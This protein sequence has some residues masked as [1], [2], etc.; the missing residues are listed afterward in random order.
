[1]KNDI[2][3]LEITDVTP[4]GYGIGRL[5]GKVYFVADTVTGDIC[6]CLVLKELK[7]HSFAKLIEIIKPSE[8][9]ITPNCT[10]CRQC[11][12]CAYRHISYEYELELKRNTVK[13]AFARIAKLD[14]A[15][16]P[17]VSDNP[18]HYRNKVQYPFAQNN[19]YAT[20]GY[21]AKRSHRIV[22]HKSCPLQDKIFSDI[23]AYTAE[24]ADRLSLP[25][26]D[27]ESGKGVIR[28]AV[29][30]KNRKNQILLCLVVAK[31]H[32]N[33][34]LLAEALTAKFP[35]IIGVHINVNTR[36]DNVIFGDE[37]YRLLGSETL[38]DMLCG[39]TFEISPRA[40]YQVNAVM[41]E[42]LYSHA[43]S[44][45]KRDC[46]SAVILDLYCGAGTI[47]ICVAG[48]EDKLCGVEIIDAAIENARTNALL[49][50]RNEKNTLF[51]CGDAS[52]GVEECRKKFGKPNIIIVDPPRKGLDKTVIETVV[53]ASPER[54][55]YISC[56]PATLA[57][58]CAVFAE[59]GYF[60]SE[61]TPFDLFPRTG[62]VETVVCL[63]KEGEIHTMKLDH[64]PFEKIKSGQKTI[65]LRLLDEKRRSIKKGDVIIF[66]DNSNGERLKATV[67]KLHR[68]ESFEQLYKSLPLLKCGYTAEELGSAH[69]SD[70]EKYYSAEEQKKHGVIGI[71][72]FP[73]K[74]T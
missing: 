13:Q 71:E 1:M 23:A 74:R 45:A 58:D 8:H 27:E 61:A 53:K 10:V 62:H 30:R 18:E 38:T 37:T 48:K 35:A 70:M 69:H 54:I 68:F 5:D 6:S 9:R 64:S 56:D 15:V 16:N 44:L 32:R 46:E 49:N 12:G 52:V 40:F 43:A 4:E 29:M 25:A 2:I 63:S 22:E 51:V 21:Y 11:G 7:S 65:E 31:K 42:K 47:G 34:S 17:T 72:L 39:K 41:A 59:S 3:T 28:H 14:I 60:A 19:G 57:R 66:T 20:F 73:P 33:L 26:Y 55:V 50:Q 24:L 36:R 67:K